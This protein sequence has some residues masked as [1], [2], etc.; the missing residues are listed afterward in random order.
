MSLYRYALEK[1]SWQVLGGWIITPIAFLVAQLVGQGNNKYITLYLVLS[2]ASVGALLFLNEI[3]SAQRAYLSSSTSILKRN[4]C[5]VGLFQ[6][7]SVGVSLSFAPDTLWVRSNPILVSILLLASLS[8]SLLCYDCSTRFNRYL[9]SKSFCFRNTDAFSFGIIPQL[10]SQS[11]ILFILFAGAEL[12][13]IQAIT[14]LSILIVLPSLTLNIW[15]R[16]KVYH[17][18]VRE[19]FLQV[20]QPF[21]F[22]VVIVIIS[23]LSLSASSTL[24]KAYVSYYINSWGNL[25]FIALNMLSTASM[26][27]GK[28]LFLSDSS[29]SP[30]II[31][32]KI[33][34]FLYICILLLS[35]LPILR[36][37]RALAGNPVLVCS[38]ILIVLVLSVF[39]QAVLFFSRHIRYV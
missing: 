30:A 29:A 35:I 36:D 9:V 37:N 28:A 20:R 15:L 1:L 17:P 6:L 12:T 5:L 3:L 27:L 32:P 2:S 26:M 11:F 16:S 21:R 18:A 25:M 7:I 22:E 31:P 39:Q 19:N 13:G 23:L 33:R 38:F 24:L 34:L 10:V 4:E 14:V 8:S